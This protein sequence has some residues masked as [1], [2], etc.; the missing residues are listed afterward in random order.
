MNV[1]EL[2]PND[3]LRERLSLGIEGH[4]KLGH[5]GVEVRRQIRKLLLHRRQGLPGASH[6]ASLLVGAPVTFHRRADA[7][8]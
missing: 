6:V 4:I 7:P 1:A 8:R 5:S 2:G 3:H